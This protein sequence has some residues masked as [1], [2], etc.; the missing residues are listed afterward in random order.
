MENSQNG[1]NAVLPNRSSAEHA[2]HQPSSGPKLALF[3]ASSRQVR[4]TLLWALAGFIGLQAALAVGIEGCLPELRDPLYA[5][6]ARRLC[7]R[8]VEDPA[9]PFSVV[10]L[11]S[12]RA[13]FGFKAGLLEKPLTET[14]G[15]P[16]VV[17]NF[18]VTGAGPVTSLMMLR[19][20]AG[21]R[22]PPRL[23]PPRSLAA[24]AQ[25]QAGSGRGESP[26]RGSALAA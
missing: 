11:G 18:G 2:L 16:V 24:A 12:S 9:K 22:S 7:E 10:L 6:K 14:M 17:F 5:F 20:T 26:Q 23:P 25:R 8:T 3:E 1:L 4:R 21:G 15:R 13:I 19:T